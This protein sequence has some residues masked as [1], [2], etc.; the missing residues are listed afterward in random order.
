ML[1]NQADFDKQSHIHPGDPADAEHIA[2]NWHYLERQYSNKGYAK[3]RIT[4]KAAM[5]KT[6]H[7]VSYT[8]SAES[9]P[10]YTMGHL[11]IENVG[12]DIRNMMLAAWTMKQGGTFNEG[13]ILSYY[14]MDQ[15]DAKAAQRLVRLF[16]S[17]N[18]KFTL[19][20]NDD[21]K[22]VDV[23]LRLEKRTS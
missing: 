1:V 22:T 16:R 17:V 4:P 12:D 6:L 21:T 19:H 23:V 13:K 7:T 2:Q 11:T 15:S 20:L 3:A 9:G 18:C 5:D 10:V 8:V 14:G